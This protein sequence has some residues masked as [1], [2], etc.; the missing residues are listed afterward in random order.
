MAKVHKLCK[1]FQSWC[2]VWYKSFDNSIHVKSAHLRDSVK[3]SVKASQGFSNTFDFWSTWV[4]CDLSKCVFVI[5]THLGDGAKSSQGFLRTF[6]LWSTWAC[7]D[8]CRCVCCCGRLRFR[9]AV[10]KIDCDRFG[11]DAAILINMKS[12]RPAWRR[13]SALCGTSTPALSFLNC[14]TVIQRMVSSITGIIPLELLGC[15]PKNGQ[16]TAIIPRTVRST[17][18]IILLE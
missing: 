15:N 2:R 4:C 11:H 13:R 5:S 6:D 14:L 3:D 16:I 12:S 17:T 1:K 9:Y 18:G 7:C 8:L 10:I